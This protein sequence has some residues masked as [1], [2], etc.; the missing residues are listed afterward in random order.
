MK[1]LTEIFKKDLSNALEETENM[2]LQSLCGKLDTIPYTDITDVV[3]VSL[4]TGEIVP[5]KA[6][7]VCESQS[8]RTLLALNKVVGGNAAKVVFDSDRQKLMEKLE[9]IDG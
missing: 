7:V 4:R 2:D 5:I 6:P 1:K 8:N 3:L 9:E